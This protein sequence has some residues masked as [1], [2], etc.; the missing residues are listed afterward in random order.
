MK[1]HWD[2]F[3]SEYSIFLCRYHSSIAPYLVHVPVAATRRANPK[4]LGTF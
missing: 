4:S 3:A 1:W 2:M